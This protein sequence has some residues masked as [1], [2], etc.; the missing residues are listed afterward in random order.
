M[1]RHSIRCET[2]PFTNQVIISYLYLLRERIWYF[3]AQVKALN[4]IHRRIESLAA[5]NQPMVDYSCNVLG[6]LCKLCCF[7]NTTL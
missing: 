3:K 2:N 7:Y 5:Y 1:E 6:L 4:L